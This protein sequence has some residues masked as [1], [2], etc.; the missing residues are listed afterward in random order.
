MI[1]LKVEKK[2]LN[3]VKSNK[4]GSIELY[5][6]DDLVHEIQE[7]ELPVTN[8]PLTGVRNV[9]FNDAKYYFSD[10]RIIGTENKIVSKEFDETEIYYALKTL[11]K[12]KAKE[13]FI[14]LVAPEENCE[15]LIGETQRTPNE[16]AY[17]VI[18]D[19]YHAGNSKLLLDDN[20][21]EVQ[22]A[23]KRLIEI[24]LQFH[25]LENIDATIVGE[26]SY[27]VSALRLQQTLRHSK[28]ALIDPEFDLTN[29]KEFSTITY[30][31]NQKGMK[32]DY[33]RI[34]KRLLVDNS[35]ASLFVKKQKSLNGLIKKFQLQ[36]IGLIDSKYRF[37]HSASQVFQMQMPIVLRNNCFEIDNGRLF[38]QYAIRKEDDFYLN[39]NNVR[40]CIL[41]ILTN[42]KIITCEMTVDRTN[43]ELIY[44]YEP[45]KIT[46]ELRKLGTAK[47]EI[48]IYTK[49]KKITYIER[50]VTI[51]FE[52]A[53][54][55][56]LI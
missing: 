49:Q 30:Y 47:I 8:I 21:Q 1:E 31:M 38:V 50:R 29:I 13:L 35:N 39:F 18:Y 52:N 34:A 28:L 22:K 10:E 48:E 2:Y 32:L 55:I 45:L 46:D 20:N 40:Y 33:T 51:D 36:K 5:F 53:G 6:D 12:D 43:N 37:L 14:F 23:I 26:G 41:K 3:I 17:L 24:V 42:D 27:A 54:V 56:N 16:R 9:S 11:P 19:Y 44:L 7:S 25:G 4:S 15:Y